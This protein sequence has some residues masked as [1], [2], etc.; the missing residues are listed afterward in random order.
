M[1]V[2]PT[3]ESGFTRSERSTQPCAIGMDSHKA[4]E[5]VRERRGDVKET[6]LRPGWEV[7]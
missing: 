1:K 5:N 2:L 6:N 7:R 3:A 4:N